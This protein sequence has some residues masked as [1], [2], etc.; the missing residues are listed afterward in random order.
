MSEVNIHNASPEDV[1][2]NKKRQTI[3]LKHGLSVRI[4]GSWGPWQQE[5]WDNHQFNIDEYSEILKEN[6]LI[7]SKKI[8][9]WIGILFL[10]PAIL[11]VIAFLLSWFDFNGEFS[12]LRNL[13]GDWTDGDNCSSPAPIYLGLVSIAGAYLLKDSSKYLFYKPTPTA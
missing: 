6:Q 11:G 13:R 4:D 3:M 10:L 8:E 1:L 9:C 7:K 2:Y 12:S 5:Q